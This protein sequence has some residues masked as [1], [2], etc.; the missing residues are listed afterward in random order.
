MK[1][2][3]TIGT[4]LLSLITFFLGFVFMKSLTYPYN[5]E[6]RYFDEDSATVH[7]EQAVTAYGIMFFCGLLLTLVMLYK[8][9]KVFYK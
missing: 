4:V 6:G 2:V 7:H 9:R 8:T 5:S 1:L 3:M